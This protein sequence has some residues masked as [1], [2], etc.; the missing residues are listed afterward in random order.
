MKVGETLLVDLSNTYTTLI[1]IS[2]H[3]L[4]LATVTMHHV[5][6]HVCPVD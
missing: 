1:T 2:D 4:T 6:I 3:C 5:I